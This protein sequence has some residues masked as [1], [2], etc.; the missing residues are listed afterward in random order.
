MTLAFRLYSMA[1]L[2]ANN[3]YDVVLGSRIL[4]KG[5]LKGGMPLYKYLANRIEILNGD[6][7]CKVCVLLTK[8][9][10]MCQLLRTMVTK[11]LKN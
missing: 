8:D 11:S 4:N 5:A 10:V 7:F 2:I 1:H 6:S 9:K 3:V